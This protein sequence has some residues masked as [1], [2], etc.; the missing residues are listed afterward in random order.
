M[1]GR[2]FIED[3]ASGRCSSTD[4][5]LRKPAVARGERSEVR[6]RRGSS[7]LVGI[8][9]GETPVAPDELNHRSWTAGYAMRFRT[10]VLFLCLTVST[11]ISA[12]DRARGERATG[13]D[14]ADFEVETLIEPEG[15]EFF[16]FVFAP[17][18]FRD[19]DEDRALFLEQVE[20][21]TTAIRTQEP[22]ASLHDKLKFSVAWVPSKNA[23]I[24][25]TAEYDRDEGVWRDKISGKTTV[26]QTK[27]NVGR[28]I[29]E[30]GNYHSVL[31]A[32]DA[33]EG[34][35]D[36]LIVIA[37]EKSYGGGARH[38]VDLPG[39]AFHVHRESDTPL[40]YQEALERF[41]FGV[42]IVSCEPDI[43]E[44][45]LIHELGH[46]IANLGEEY[47]RADLTFPDDE[48][49][50]GLKKPNV[51]G[52]D[53]RDQIK[54][55]DL[56]GKN[57]VG[58]YEGAE[59]YGKGVFRPWDTGCIMRSERNTAFCPVCDRAIR[60]AMREAMRMEAASAAVR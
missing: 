31:A 49:H 26:F 50:P 47:F 23:G 51:S 43:A 55:K 57:G 30:I 41:T 5:R 52:T 8:R 42:T 36:N 22:F 40:D 4:C 37:N 32:V 17:D 11:T 16:H 60:E 14:V 10:A 15:R 33:V 34:R 59:G 25:D 44:R 29:I 6:S 53:D 13:A 9:T 45:I 58:A 46:S 7:S 20:R 27:L 1:A 2:P 24:P 12:E 3:R 21:N 28:Y 54:W 35:V 38:P 39:V 18:G 48:N 19:T 56:F